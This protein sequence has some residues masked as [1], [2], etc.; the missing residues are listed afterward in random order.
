MDH[1][2]LQPIII[3]SKHRRRRK[4]KRRVRLGPW[5]WRAAL[6]AVVLGATGTLVTQA[7]QPYSMR[8]R[9]KQETREM[10]QQLAEVKEENRLL[11]LQIQNLRSGVGLEPEAR[12]LGYIR[13]GEVPLLITYDEPKKASE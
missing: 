5:I 8:Y 4:A 3:T 2:P 7:F 9:Q 10:L 11:K 6:G 1:D 12:K 13:E